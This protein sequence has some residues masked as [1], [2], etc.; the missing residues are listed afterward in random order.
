MRWAFDA[1][2]HIHMGRSLPLTAFSDCNYLGG[3]AIMSTHP[4]DFATVKNLA[5]IPMVSPNKDTNKPKKVII[6]GY[7]IHPWFL[8]ELEKSQWEKSSQKDDKDD[9]NTRKD[10]PI[11]MQ[12]IIQMLE[13]DP[14]AIVGEIGLDG[15]HFEAKTGNLKS[16]MSEQIKVF[17]M[18]LEIAVRLQRPVSIH[19]V[20][21]FGPL[22]TSL[23]KFQKGTIPEEVEDDDAHN[24]LCHNSDIDVHNRRR[25][26]R[27]RQRLGLPPKL[28]FH[29]FG[30]KVGTVDQLVALCETMEGEKKDSS[31]SRRLYFGF[32]PVVNFRSPKTIQVIRKI[33]LERLVLETDHEESSLVP[34]SIEDG[35]SYIANAL[36]LSRDEVI[37]QTTRNAC[38]L[39]GIDILTF[40]G[41]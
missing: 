30:G 34:Q 4:R 14:K 20:Q 11:W 36:D 18:Q 7:G 25:C 28:Y 32:A 10:N 37:E 5:D 22:L 8:H 21:A 39:Y 35:I 31:K 29:A 27:R 9:S 33:G 19:V 13:S 2:N 15:F 24:T 23:S 1:H 26:C 12:T 6:P 17:E 16:P 41:K 3:V 40:Q 38:D